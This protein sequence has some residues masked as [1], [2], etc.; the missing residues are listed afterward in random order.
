M[1]DATAFVIAA[2]YFRGRG[3]YGLGVISALFG[4]LHQGFSLYWVL[5]R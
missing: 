2:L 5:A 1:S 3:W 4:V